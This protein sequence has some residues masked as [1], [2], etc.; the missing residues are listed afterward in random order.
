MSHEAVSDDAAQSQPHR[1]RLPS[2]VGGCIQGARLLKKSPT[3]VV[4]R[5]VEIYWA[6]DKK[7]YPGR[8]SHY[9]E[10]QQHKVLYEDGEQEMLDLSAEMW[11]LDK[12]ATRQLNVQ[13]DLSSPEP[14]TL[15]ETAGAPSAFDQLPSDDSADG[16]LQHARQHF[17]DKNQAAEALDTAAASGMVFLLP[18]Q[19]DLRR[20][21]ICY[22]DP[23]GNLKLQLT[24][25]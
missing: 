5:N 19:V 11:R 14:D 4:D 15:P 17:Q 6:K 24:C 13:D 12:N 18:R 9:T 7:W 3:A 10:N 25:I 23:H 1:G 20:P 22:A 8:V 2:K 16:R 21:P